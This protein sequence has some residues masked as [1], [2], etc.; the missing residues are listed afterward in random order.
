MAPAAAAGAVSACVRGATPAAVARPAAAAV[1]L[2]AP[3]TFAPGLHMRVWFRVKVF[4]IIIIV[5]VCCITHK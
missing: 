2:L 4:W 5:E 3:S 1:L